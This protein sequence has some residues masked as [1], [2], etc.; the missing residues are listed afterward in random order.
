MK[1]IVIRFFTDKNY[2][3]IE[4]ENGKTY[5]LHPS[6]LLSSPDKDALTVGVTLEF[7]ELVTVKGLQAINIELKQTTAKYELYFGVKSSRSSSIEDYEI[8]DSSIWYV[9]GSSRGDPKSAKAAMH[10]KA[11]ELGANA[12]LDYRYFSTTGSESGTSPGGVHHFTIHNYR[13]R[14]A[15]IGRRSL[16]GKHTP[17]DLQGRSGQ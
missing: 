4:G 9:T 12:V 16:E 8:L 7:D 17:E 3:F 14:V 2:G 6:K 10:Y 13:G 1:G 5:F 11:R 15:L